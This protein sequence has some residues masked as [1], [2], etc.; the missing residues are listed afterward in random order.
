MTGGGELGDLLGKSAV[1]PYGIYFI[2]P[3]ERTTGYITYSFIAQSER[4]PRIIVLAITAY[5]NNFEAIHER[6]RTLLHDNKRVSCASDFSA[7]LMIKWDWA[8]PELFDDEI[9]Q[10]YQQQ[11]YMIKAW[12]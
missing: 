2:A 8:G 5:G 10:Y 4:K 9:K 7:G 12:K 3:P 6:I 1:S 11:R